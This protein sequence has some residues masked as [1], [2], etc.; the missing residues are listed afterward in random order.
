MPEPEQTLNEVSSQL[1]M[2]G[3]D[4]MSSMKPNPNESAAKN[5]EEGSSLVSN[6]FHY[7]TLDMLC[8]PL[9]VPL[10]YET[11]SPLEIAIFEA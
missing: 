11:W 8:N 10:G 3:N 7:S 9:R 2:G 4:A 1:P 5:G 6:D